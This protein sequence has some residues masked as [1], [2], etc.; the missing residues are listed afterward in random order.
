MLFLPLFFSLVKYHLNIEW[1]LSKSG[2]MPL[3]KNVN[4]D[5]FLNVPKCSDASVDKFNV[6]THFILF[7]LIGKSNPV[8]MLNNKLL[9]DKQDRKYWK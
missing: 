3:L 8:S 2:Q 7:Y 4:P 5:L 9:L 6:N 1:Q